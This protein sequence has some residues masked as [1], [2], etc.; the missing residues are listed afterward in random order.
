MILAEN[1][2]MAIILHLAPISYDPA[3]GT[4]NFTTTHF[5]SYAVVYVTKTF[6]DLR[7]VGWAKENIEVLASKGILKGISETE[8]APQTNISRADFLYF[9]VRTLGV[10]EK[11]DGNYDD[12]DKNA[13]YCREAAIAKNLGITSDTGNNK[14]TPDASITR[15]DM[16]VLTERALRMLKKLE[17]QG[18]ASGLDKFTDKSLVAT[19]AVNGEASVVLCCKER[20]DCGQWW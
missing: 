11:I 12:I 13:Y 8:Y 6:D 17:A 15:Q 18:T 10:D 7:N 1:H 16:M 9:M 20:F 2:E 4:V 5:S 19:Y 14:F 3:T